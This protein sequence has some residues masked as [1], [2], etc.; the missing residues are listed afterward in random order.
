[1]V[2]RSGEG[3]TEQTPYFQRHSAAVNLFGELS[4]FSVRPAQ[5]GAAWAAAGVLTT[6]S[7]GLFKSSSQRDPARRSYCVS[8]RTSFVRGG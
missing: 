2:N 1:M 3:D 5:R 8:C 4:P 7:A 6:N